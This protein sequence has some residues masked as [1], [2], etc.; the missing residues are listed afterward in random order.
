MDIRSDEVGTDLNESYMI[1][2]KSKSISVVYRYGKRKHIVQIIDSSNNQYRWY[3]INIKKQD[4]KELYIENIKKYKD[5]SVK[6]IR[7]TNGRSLR[8]PY[9][10]PMCNKPAGLPTYGKKELGVEFAFDIRS[11][12]EK[13]LLSKT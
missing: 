9:H 10:D 5:N 12:I 1:V 8:L 2:D 6:K 3:I 4:I 11:K 7:F 13:M